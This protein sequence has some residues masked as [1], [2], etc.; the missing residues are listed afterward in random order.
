M[1]ASGAATPRLAIL[2]ATKVCR[3]VL[4]DIVAAAAASAVSTPVCLAACSA[5]TRDKAIC[6]CANSC[7]DTMLE[8]STD[9]P[10]GEEGNTADG[11][12]L[13]GTNEIKQG[14]F[15]VAP[16]KGPFKTRMKA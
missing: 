14:V 11:R 2:G 8:E 16:Q 7:S 13:I 5:R 10:R 4:A 3:L 6:I 9:S 12:L 1:G 15:K